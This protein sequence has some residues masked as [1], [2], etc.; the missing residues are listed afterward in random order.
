MSAQEWIGG[1]TCGPNMI[2][3]ENGFVP[4]TTPREFTSAPS[5]VAPSR[6]TTQV[7]RQ[8]SQM[9]TGLNMDQLVKENTDLKAQLAS[10]DARIRQLE[11]QM[12]TLKN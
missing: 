6:Q 7:Q 9:K 3:L 4:S 1:K 11:A 8:P 12:E 2:N 10:K 5:S